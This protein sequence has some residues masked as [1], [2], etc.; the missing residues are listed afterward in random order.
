[1]KS[2]GRKR[3]AIVLSALAA[4]VGLSALGL[5]CSGRLGT[6]SRHVRMK[7][8]LS[9]DKKAMRR[10]EA[11]KLARFA[12]DFRV[13]AQRYREGGESKK[14]HRAIGAA[15]ELDRKIKKLLEEDGKPNGSGK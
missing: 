8:E 4:V 7:D 5:S 15:Q 2:F 9:E 6:G 14:A 3:M 10:Q 1:M 11:E 13:L 12:R